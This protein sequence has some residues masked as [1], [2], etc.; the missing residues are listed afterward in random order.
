MAN[1]TD[2]TDLNGHVDLTDGNLN[3]ISQINAGGTVYDIATH[4][5]ITFREGNNGEAIVWNGLTD[6]EVVIPSITDIVQTPIEFA[7]TVGADGTVTWNEG[8]TDGPQVGYL[9]FVTADCTFAE[10]ACEAGDMAI[11]DGTNWNIVSGENQVTIVGT[12]QSN[13]EDVNRTTVAVGS[14]KDVL[15]VEGKALSLTLDYADLN[16]HVNVTKG[17]E[18]NVTFNNATVGGTYVKLTKSA[19]TDITIGTDVTLK[20]ATQLADGTVTLENATDLVNEVNFGTFDAGKMP[21][22]TQNSEKKLDIAGG[23]LTATVGQTTGDFID[24]ITFGNITFVPADN[25]DANKINLV[26]DIVAADGT[27]FL[28]GIHRTEEGENAD[29]TIAGHVAPTNGISTT[30]VEGLKDGLST[31]V[32]SISDGDFKLVTGEDLATGF[33]EEQEGKD[34]DVIS[35]VTVSANND[36]SVLNTAEV[37]DHVLT[38]GTTNVTSSVSVA[39]KSKSLQKTGFEYTAPKATNTE[40]VTS[41]FSKVDDVKYTFGR[42]NETTYTTTTEMWKL[43]TPELVTTKGTYEINHTNMKATIPASTFVASATDGV[44]PT[45]SGMGTNKVTVTG[46]VATGLSYEDV[47]I[48]T[49]VDDI[50]KITL[51]GEYSLT[52]ASVG[53]DNTVLVGKSGELS[54]IDATIDLKDY[55]TGIEIK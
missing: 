18:V 45:W 7:G 2:K 27:E 22:F 23:T 50:E 25:N 46:S 28:T 6:L 13:I 19:D 30:F 43:N 47:T 31:V 49:L 44:L 34:G 15:V 4:H 35:D 48:H 37:K 24:S 16:T 1:I 3:W 54:G 41:G 17:T 20:K 55:I 11:Y 26:T 29:L 8:H 12:T 36:T 52:E 32:T 5:G 39:Y 42:D 51:P 38:F 9:V 40:F 14:A 21:T 53:G 10:K 33:G